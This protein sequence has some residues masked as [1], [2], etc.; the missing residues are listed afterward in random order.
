[1]GGS[2]GSRT[3]QDEITKIYKLMAVLVLA[4]T[5]CGLARDTNVSQDFSASIISLEVYGLG[6]EWGHTR[7]EMKLARGNEKIKHE[8]NGIPPVKTKALSLVVHTGS[9]TSCTRSAVNISASFC[10]ETM[11]TN[12]FVFLR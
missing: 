9:G 12:E 2:A 4:A 11:Q 10:I 3:C 1:M 8:K 6:S 5:P 7:R